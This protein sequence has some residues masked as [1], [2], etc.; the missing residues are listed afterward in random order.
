MIHL[1]L[2]EASRSHMPAVPE[3]SG[4]PKAA[5]I[6]TWHGRMVNE[7][8][9]SAVFAARAVCSAFATALLSTFSICFAACFLLKRSSANASL[10]RLPRT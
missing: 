2:R 4:A 5:A 1:D 7:T 10:T 6:G 9:S 3:T 8:R